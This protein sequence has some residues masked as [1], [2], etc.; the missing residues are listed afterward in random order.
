VEE[1]L[2]PSVWKNQYGEILVYRFP[3]AT[4][5]FKRGRLVNAQIHPEGSESVYGGPDKGFVIWSGV[6]RRDSAIEI[7]GNHSSNGNLYGELPGVPVSVNVNPE[8]IAIQEVPGPDNDWKRLVLR[9][10]TQRHIVVT[11]NW[12]TIQ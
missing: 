8:D 6:L 4:L 10:K 5:F 9:S 12:K 2:G 3:M 1:T 11:I 7:D